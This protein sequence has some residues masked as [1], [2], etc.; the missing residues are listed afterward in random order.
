MPEARR[1]G[2]AHARRGG[3]PADARDLL[4]GAGPAGE[5]QRRVR[6]RGGR[7]HRAHQPD[8]QRQA[9]DKVAALEPRLARLR[10]VVTDEVRALPGLEIRRAGSLV[11]AAQWGLSLPADK[12]THAV[13]VTTGDGRRWESSAVI[14]ADGS[15]VDL[16]VELPPAPPSPTRP[17]EPPRAGEPA[18]PRPIPARRCTRA[19]SRASSSARRA[20]GPWWRAPRSGSPPSSTGTRATPPGAATRPAT[21][22]TP[23][24]SS[25]GRACA[26]ATCRR[27]CSSAEASARR[28]RGPLRHGARARP[29]C[30]RREARGR[31]PRDRYPGQ[32]L[33]RAISA[34]F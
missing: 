2:A 9:H 27:R 24:P 4:R 34:I 28:R 23:A 26:R 30:G 21:A 20:S 19:A 31:P 12:G 5:R 7:R 13:V 10:I 25:G 29:A 6:A 1:G 17:V 8:R 18:G 32:L 33:A 22:P 14:D 16:R 3:R 15:H 11:G